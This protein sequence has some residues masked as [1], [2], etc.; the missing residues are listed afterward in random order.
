VSS[1]NDVIG[2]AP[3]RINALAHISIGEFAV[4]LVTAMSSYGEGKLIP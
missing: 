4:V 1:S 2:S 3:I